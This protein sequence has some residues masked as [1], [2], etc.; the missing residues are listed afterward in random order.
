MLLRDI[1]YIRFCRPDPLVAP[2]ALTVYTTQYH[3]CRQGPRD[4]HAT[5]TVVRGNEGAF[6]RRT[7]VCACPLS[8]V[9]PAGYAP[10]GCAP[11][12][13]LRLLDGAFHPLILLS[14][15][16]LALL[17]A[18]LTDLRRTTCTAMGDYEQ[19]MARVQAEEAA[20][21]KVNKVF[22]LKR[23]RRPELPAFI[24]EY[25]RPSQGDARSCGVPPGR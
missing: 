18:T 1:R 7:W 19:E 5:L 14:K 24:Y 17:E 11:H 23:P 2:G 22:R 10:V 3:T 25:V 13:L 6:A 16:D 9:R 15:D 21:R 8:A 20:L 4:L 12:R